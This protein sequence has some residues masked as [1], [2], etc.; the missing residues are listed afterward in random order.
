MLLIAYTSMTWIIAGRS[1][2]IINPLI[3]ALPGYGG[4]GNPLPRRYRWYAL[5]VNGIQHCIA[6]QTWKSHSL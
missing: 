3:T 2:I 1:H 6:I 5:I 4:E